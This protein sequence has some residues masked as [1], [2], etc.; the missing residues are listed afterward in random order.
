[1]TS[2]RRVFIIGGTE[3]AAERLR[4]RL[5]QRGFDTVQTR[6]GAALVPPSKPAPTGTADLAVVLNDPAP[7]A[8]SRPDVKALLEGLAAKKITT[9]VQTN[10]RAAEID[11]G[12]WVEWLSPDV[13]I[14]ELVG[15]LETLARYAPLVRAMERELDHLHRLGDQLNRYFGQIDQEMR[16][17]GRLQ[18]DFLPR[19]MP[20]IPPFS[21]EVLY[22]PASWVS[23]DMYDVFR[24]DTNHVGLFVAD[25]MGH[26]VAAGLLTMF[27][28]QALAPRRYPSP[29]PTIRA[30]AEVLE[31]L[32]HCLVRQNL[33]NSQFVTAVYGLLDTQTRQL[34]IARGGHPYPLRIRGDGTIEELRA[35]GSLLGL[36][37][38]PAEFVP[39][40]VPLQPRDHV[41][42]YTDGL[43]DV[44]LS[45][46]PAAI[47]SEE[48]TFTEQF[49]EWA[50]LDAPGLVR[51]IGEHV[52]GRAGSLH[53][54]DDMTLLVLAVQ[55]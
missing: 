26:G 7:M 53:P 6:E 54:A 10:D 14:D 40:C 50:K 55:E 36:T 2:N 23:G 47:G 13:S 44:F 16:L 43:E 39:L 48:P 17:A 5:R 24:V 52:D 35:G 8:D 4:D 29:T 34:C 22:R 19:E 28:R 32:H 27:I 41:I 21:F 46:E 25:A 42:F 37:D 20:T 1:M 12:P 18:R 51:A 3:T 11:A 30:P 9:L 15:R 31:D 49:R 38:V 45:P 33:P